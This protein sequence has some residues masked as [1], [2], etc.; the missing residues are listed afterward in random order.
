MQLRAWAEYNPA[1]YR[2]HQWDGSVEPLVALG[3]ALASGKSAAVSSATGTGKTF[4]A[5]VLTFWWLDCWRGGQVVTVAPKKDQLTLHI[6][7]EIGRLWPLFQRLH[8]QAELLTLTI[9]MRPGQPDRI[10]VDE[11]GIPLAFTGW[12]AVGF[13]CGVGASE[14]V[15]G[16]ARG[17]HAKDLLFVVEETPGVHEAVLTAIRVTCTGPHNLRLFLGNPDSQDDPLA[18]VSREQGVVAIRASAL[19]HP[20]IVLDSADL[21]PGAASRQ[22]VEEWGSDYGHDSPLYQSRVRGLTPTQSMEALIRA[23]W[24][25]VAMARPAD[26]RAQARQGEPA[27]GVDVA[28]SDHGDMAS[29]A[30]GRGA[31]CEEVTSSRCPDP[32][33]WTRQQVHPRLITLGVPAH[34]VGV[35]IVGVGVGAIG[36]FKRLGFHAIGLNGGA[37]YRPDLAKDGEEFPNLRSQ[38]W[39]QLRQDLYHGRI[40]LP[41]DQE[42]LQ[43]LVAPKWWTRGGKVVV[44]SKEDFKR[45]L[46]RSPD[47][48]DAV[49][50]WNWMRQ[51]FAGIAFT[52]APVRWA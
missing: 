43:D 12:G 52:Q 46:G 49:V 48:G 39:W 3:Q 7:K 16:K 21:I 13:V 10:E 36:E 35:D 15:A 1:A 45:R 19:D 30:V 28:A 20:N 50:Y 26:W 38:M 25:E 2:Q 37:A 5:A 18:Q 40:A 33:A 6:W 17:F 4:T 9:R 47:K 34:R 31:V 44:E 29:L 27:A 41:K 23:E 24:V 22:R 51:G 42:L 8:P 14:E 32:N 11:A